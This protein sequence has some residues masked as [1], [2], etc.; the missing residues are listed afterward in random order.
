MA[1]TIRM[2]RAGGKQ[3]PCYHIV[4]ADS[5]RARCGQYI[6]KIGFF[7]PRPA[8]PVFL[9]DRERYDAWVKVG[10]KVSRTVAQLVA[11]NPAPPAP[12]APKQG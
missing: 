6:E 10:A 4:A 2:K 9:M 7:D 1:A 11:K 3:K 5:R 12:P 8:Q